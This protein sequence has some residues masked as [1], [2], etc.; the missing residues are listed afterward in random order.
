[1]FIIQTLVYPC[2]ISLSSKNHL[3]GCSSSRENKTW[4]FQHVETWLRSALIKSR[5]KPLLILTLFTLNNWKNA[6]QIQW[7]MQVN[8]QTWSHR[9]LSWWVWKQRKAIISSISLKNCD[10]SHWNVTKFKC[11]WFWCQIQF[12]PLD[13]VFFKPDLNF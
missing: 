5:S 9:T 7:L 10:S 1:M 3:G 4:M 13:S 11:L 12:K 8:H 6:A 2:L